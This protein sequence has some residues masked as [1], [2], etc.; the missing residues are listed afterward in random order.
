MPPSLL[1]L[2]LL[3]LHQRL[4][5]S[6]NSNNTSPPPFHPASPARF[7]RVQFGWCGAAGAGGGRRGDVGEADGVMNRLRRERRHQ[8]VTCS[9]WTNSYTAKSIAHSRA[10]LCEKK[11]CHSVKPQRMFDKKKLGKKRTD[12]CSYTYPSADRGVATEGE[13]T[14]NTQKSR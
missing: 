11:A 3:L 12:E 2:L 8:H 6:K 9:V 7:A 13:G 14:P 1:T 4:H 10:N 5:I